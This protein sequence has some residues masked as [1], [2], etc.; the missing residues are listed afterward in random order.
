MMEEDYYIIYALSR[1]NDGEPLVGEID[2]NIKSRTYASTEIY[3][4]LSPHNRDCNIPLSGASYILFSTLASDN[5][6]TFSTTTQPR[7]NIFTK[8]WYLWVIIG[9]ITILIIILF[10]ILCIGFTCHGCAWI[11]TYC[12]PSLF[13]EGD[14]EERQ[15]LL[16]YTGYGVYEGEPLPLYIGPPKYDDDE[17]RDRRSPLVS[18]GSVR[19]FKSVSSSR[20]SPPAYD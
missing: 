19:S 1:R 15:G 9:I 12:F 20:S 14:D 7:S 6:Y 16:D 11:L 2:I 4:S 3:C 18:S 17:V 13:D 10:I 5:P 8:Y